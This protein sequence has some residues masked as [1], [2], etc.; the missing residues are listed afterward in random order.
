L[1]HKGAT[2]SQILL[3]QI[4]INSPLDAGAPDPISDLIAVPGM[5]DGKVD[6]SWTATGDDPGGVG[7]AVK[8]EVRYS[9]EPIMD[10]F[11]WRFATPAAGVIPA[12]QA[13]GTTE[14]ATVIGLTP[15]VQYYFAVMAF[16]NANY[17]ILSTSSG[18]EFAIATYSAG[19]WNGAG[20]YD[21][22]GPGWIY[23]GIWLLQPAFATGLATNGTQHL[24]GSYATSAVFHFDGTG[25]ILTFQRNSGLGK[26]DVYIDG[27]K[28]GRINQYAP[29]S[30]WQWTWD[31]I[32]YLGPLAQTPVY[33]PNDYHVVEFRRIGT[34]VTIDEIQI[35]P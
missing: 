18:T 11:D 25:F 8:Y 13:A 32:V 22:A 12:P 35:I 23:N 4:Y 30:Q 2:D 3:D 7:T 29:S 20:I 6:L 14:S 1:V 34:R 16:D 19:T 26:L 5:T 24:G 33:A 10:I 21:D 9:P 31:S 15:G 17:A 28:M 27:V